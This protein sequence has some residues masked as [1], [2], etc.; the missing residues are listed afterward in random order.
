MRTLYQVDERFP[1][2]KEIS[3]RLKWVE[4]LK[5]TYHKQKLRV[6]LSVDDSELL[7]PRIFCIIHRSI[8]WFHLT[9]SCLDAPRYYQHHQEHAS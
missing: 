2:K 8:H 9:P 6:F 4:V 3:S 7:A 5:P 1:Y